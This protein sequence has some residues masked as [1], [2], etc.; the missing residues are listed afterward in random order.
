MTDSPDGPPGTATLTGMLGGL[1]LAVDLS[2]DDRVAAGGD[3][4]AAAPA[5]R[6]GSRH[7]GRAGA[8]AGDTHS[9]RWHRLL[10][11]GRQARS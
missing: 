2:G 1:V 8:G 4:G 3:A 5:L 11:S 6:R 7:A 10:I 9:Q